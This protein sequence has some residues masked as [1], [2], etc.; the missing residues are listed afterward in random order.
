[1]R[2][3]RL[4]SAVDTL[5]LTLRAFSKYM[6][7]RFVQSIVDRGTAPQ[8]GGRRQPVIVMFSD[9]EGFTSIAETLTPDELMP[10]LSRYFSEIS[11]EILASGGTIDK[12]IGD[13]VMAFWPMPDDETKRVTL[14]C[15]AVLRASNRVAAVNA[16]F[17]EE[18]RPAMPTRFGLHAGEAMV[19]SVG[20]PDRMN[21][22]ALGHTVNVASR[23]EQLNKTYGTRLLVSAA[24]HDRALQDVRF[25]YVDATTVR[26][27]H[28][29]L[30]VYEL[31]PAEPFTIAESNSMEPPSTH[32]SSIVG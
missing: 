8:L 24:I 12:F 4:L 3:R 16:T 2:Y 30:N 26:G 18:G 31:L 7:L 10:Q 9:I 27:T 19:G 20:T 17:R 15:A 23:I 28:E 29:P 1:M 21:Y 25:R 13:S 5:E 32:E 11:E 6:P 14:V 22:T